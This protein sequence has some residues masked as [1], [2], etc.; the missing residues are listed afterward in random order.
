MQRSTPAYAPEFRAEAV[1][2]VRSDAKP[3]TEIACDLGVSPESL[4]QWVRRAEI[5][6]PVNIS[7]SIASR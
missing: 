3:L 2:L 4:G 1:Q 7:F 6:M 5:V